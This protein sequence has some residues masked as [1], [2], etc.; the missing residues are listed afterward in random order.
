E[1]RPYSFLDMPGDS[2]LAIWRDS[3]HFARQYGPFAGWC[4]AHHFLE[5]LAGGSD[6]ERP[7]A[8][9]WQ[10]EITSLVEPWR[11]EWLGQ[12]RT[13]TPQLAG[14]GLAGLQFFDWLSLWFCLE[15]PGTSEEPGTEPRQFEPTWQPSPAIVFHPAA[16]Q[17]RGEPRQV[18]V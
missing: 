18:T 12:D 5:L 1:G 8:Q 10:Q 6:A 17:A 7:S 13:H 15:C 2:A 14:Q 11:D 4:V 16:T 9:D 3:I